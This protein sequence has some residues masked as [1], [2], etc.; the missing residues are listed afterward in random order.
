M[1]VLEW[2]DLKHKKLNGVHCILNVH[3]VHIRFCETGYGYFSVLMLYLTGHRICEIL[4][5]II[6]TEYKLFCVLDLCM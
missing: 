6:L 1:E 4:F 2:V 3:F 5:H